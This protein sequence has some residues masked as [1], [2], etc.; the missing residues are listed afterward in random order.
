[1]KDA[2]VV[3][4]IRVRPPVVARDGGAGRSVCQTPE[5]AG[6]RAVLSAA[7]K[8]QAGAG[9]SSRIVGRALHY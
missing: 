1:M 2:S 5:A 3:A 9:V 7:N 4:A 8:L 6:A